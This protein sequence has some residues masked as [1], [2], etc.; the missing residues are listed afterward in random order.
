VHGTTDDALGRVRRT[1]N[2]KRKSNPPTKLRPAV[3]I[4]VAHTSL[5]APSRFRDYAAFR[6]EVEQII[7][8]QFVAAKGIR[9]QHQRNVGDYFERLE[10]LKSFRISADFSGCL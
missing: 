8:L 4:S 10:K 1:E 7:A 3:N 2:L 9:R 5:I 6:I